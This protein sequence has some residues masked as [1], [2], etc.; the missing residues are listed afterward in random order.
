MPAEEYL[1]MQQPFGYKVEYHDGEAVFQPRELCVDGHLLLA[2]HEIKPRHTYQPVT[3]DHQQAMKKS[4][5]NAFSDTVEFCNWPELDICK[6][7]ERNIDGYFA[8]ARGKPHSA[9]KLLLDDNG[10]VSAL[11]LFLITDK[12]TIK[13]DLLLVL[14]AFQRRGIATEM[15]S[16]A[17]NELLQQGITKIHSSWHALNQASQHWHHSLGFTDVYDQYYIHL[18][19]SWYRHEIQRLKDQGISDDLPELLRQKNYWYELLDEEWRAYL[20]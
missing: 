19:H 1:H 15:V 10:E 7:A 11:A 6:A 2:S 3:I 9:S 18:K 13:L 8:G 4:F 5:F 20:K 12:G 17:I 14:P 16:L